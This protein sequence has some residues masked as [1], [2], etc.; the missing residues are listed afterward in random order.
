MRK[1]SLIWVILPVAAL[2]AF[3]SCDKDDDDDTSP[4]A[5]VPDTLLY[6]V[7]NQTVVENEYLASNQIILPRSGI[8]RFDVELLEWPGDYGLEVFLMI[9]DDYDRYVAGETFSVIRAWTFDIASSYSR[10]YY[11]PLDLDERYRIVIDNTGDGN[12][13]TDH[14]GVDDNALIN[15]AVYLEGD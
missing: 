3:V 2:L 11:D 13:D 9:E 4:V 15:L 1:R 12:A 7:T 5:P 14:D 10:H 6:E 8:L